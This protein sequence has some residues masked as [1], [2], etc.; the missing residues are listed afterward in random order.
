LIRAHFERTLS[1]EAM[2]RQLLPIYREMLVERG[3]AR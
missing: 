2:A 1:F 3:C